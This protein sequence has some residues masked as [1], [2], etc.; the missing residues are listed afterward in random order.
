MP[1]LIQYFS[2]VNLWMQARPEIGAIMLFTAMDGGGMPGVIREINSDSITVDFNHPL[3]G[4][5]VHFIE[6]LEI[7]RRTGMAMQI[8]LANPRGFCAG[9]TALSALLKTRWPLQRT[10]ICPSRKWYHNR[11]VVDS[12][13][14]RGAIFIEQISEVPDGAILIFST[15]LSPELVRNEAKSRG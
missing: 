13:R 1:D 14:E 9:A 2:A 6:V 3:A 5:T 15:V 7:D 8:L 12:L 11:Y 4:Q 10:D